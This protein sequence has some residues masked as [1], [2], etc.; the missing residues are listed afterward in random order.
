LA[1]LLLDYVPIC[2]FELHVADLAMMNWPGMLMH[3]GHENQ[4]SRE[5]L[6]NKTVHTPVVITHRNVL[7][8]KFAY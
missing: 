4:L 5:R 1:L 7:A 3:G 2:G 6:Q 8:L